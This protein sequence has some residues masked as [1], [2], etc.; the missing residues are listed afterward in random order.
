MT[1]PSSE[2]KTVVE[3]MPFDAFQIRSFTARASS[4]GDAHELSGDSI[5]EFARMLWGAFVAH[6]RT[7][8]AASGSKGGEEPLPLDRAVDWYVDGKPITY[9]DCI[10]SQCGDLALSYAEHIQT[11]ALAIAAVQPK[12]KD[13]SPTQ[14]DYCRYGVCKP[15]EQHAPGCVEYAPGELLWDHKG[16]VRHA[17]V[18]RLRERQEREHATPQTAAPAAQPEPVAWRYRVSDDR[19]WSVALRPLRQSAID[20][21]WLQEPL[22]TAAPPPAAQSDEARYYLQR[23]GVLPEWNDETPGHKDIAGA[24]ACVQY[25]KS[26]PDRPLRI[27]R[28][29]RTVVMDQA[30]I[31]AALAHK[32]TDHG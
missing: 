30:A 16:N 22:Y 7:A 28:V 17:A 29:A 11:M 8:L 14:A 10:K 20:D 19:P 27:L 23:K 1:T 21:G 26:T 31:D 24:L 5:Y 4:V 3:A 25:A 12:G 32:G 15:G 18:D 2:D 6:N 13:D 9:R